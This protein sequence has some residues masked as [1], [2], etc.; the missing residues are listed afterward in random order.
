MILLR[1]SSQFTHYLCKI[2]TKLR[3]IPHMRKFA[4][5]H[6]ILHAKRKAVFLLHFIASFIHFSSPFYIF[7]KFFSEM[8]KFVVSFFISILRKILNNLQRTQIEGIYLIYFFSLPST[9]IR[10]HT[11]PSPFPLLFP[12]SPSSHRTL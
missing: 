4:E 11:F 1:Q 3:A 9:P 8:R 7:L 5:I 12:Y 10:F 2:L 6:T